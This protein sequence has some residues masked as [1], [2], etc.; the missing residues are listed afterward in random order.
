M[1][2]FLY[3]LNSAG[4]FNLYALSRNSEIDFYT[5]QHLRSFVNSIFFSWEP[6]FEAS[7]L[8]LRQNSLLTSL[9]TALIGLLCYSET[10]LWLFPVLDPQFLKSHAFFSDLPLHF[11]EAHPPVTSWERVHGELE[12]KT[13]C[14]LKNSFILP[15]YLIDLVL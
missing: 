7:A 9:A 5:A 14:I 1:A 13:V 11:G 3:L 12:N 4:M 10:S 2:C 6:L 8:L 15:S